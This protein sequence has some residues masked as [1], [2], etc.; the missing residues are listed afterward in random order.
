MMK[1][2]DKNVL[3]G[4]NSGIE[5]NRL[6]SNLGL[7]EFARTKELLLENLPQPPAVIYDIGGGYGEYAWWLTSLGYEV[8]LFDIAE[9]NINMAAELQAEYPECV[10]AAQEVADARKILRP[11]ASADAVLLMGPLYHIVEQEE[12]LRAIVE[13]WRLLKPEGI[14]FASAITPYA[15]LL[16]ATTVYGTKN[17]LLEEEA[18][19]KMVARELLD[20]EHIRP[21]E[22]NYR[23]MGR[24]HFHS[25]N[26]LQAELEAGGFREYQVHGVVGA[27]WLAPNLDELWR[28]DVA[29][30]ALLRTV[31]LIGT[32]EDI[33]GLSTHLLS[34]SR[35]YPVG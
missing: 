29:R 32:R 23:G 25:A 8:H 33:R 22:S 24:S 26:E 13:C 15:T 21:S 28:S 12:R 9:T 5:R 4:Y 17:R 30:E 31:R 2:I 16:W 10:L 1:S 18:F 6:R 3:A 34:I 14:L 27:A 19:M 11:D 7:I 20:G 35:K